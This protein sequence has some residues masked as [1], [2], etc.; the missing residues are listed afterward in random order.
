MPGSEGRPG[1]PNKKSVRRFRVQGQVRDQIAASMES[2]PEIA[3]RIISSWLK[4]T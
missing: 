3:T 1:D 4:E 2:N